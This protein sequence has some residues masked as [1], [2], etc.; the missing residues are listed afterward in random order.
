MASAKSALQCETASFYLHEPNQGILWGVKDDG[1]SDFKISTAKASSLAQFLFRNAFEQGIAAQT[2]KDGK[3]QIIR[4]CYAHPQFD[5][6]W[7]RLT[8]F[9]LSPVSF[10]DILITAGRER[11]WWFP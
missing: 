2:A 7:D 10:L 5:Q 1:V 11:C 9:R 6:S 3:V 8:G 4:D